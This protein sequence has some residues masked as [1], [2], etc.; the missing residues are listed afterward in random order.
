M[1]G[2]TFEE[3]EHQMEGRGYY[4]DQLTGS[5]NPGQPPWLEK[6]Y[7]YETS[8]PGNHCHTF[9]DK[10]KFVN[11]IIHNCCYHGRRPVMK[12]FYIK[13]IILY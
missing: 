7:K 10:I 11:K 12:L 6:C 5:Q 4:H 2:G 13:S 3:I 1:V 9:L 8:M